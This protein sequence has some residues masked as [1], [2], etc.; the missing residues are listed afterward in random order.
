MLSYNNNGCRTIA[1]EENYP[2]TPKLTLSETLTWIHFP[3]R[4]LPGCPPTL[5]LTLTLTLTQPS[6]GGNFSWGAIVQIFYD[7]SSINNYTHPLHQVSACKYR[8]RHL[9]EIF[10]STCNLCL[11]IWNEDSF[12][13][14]K[15]SYIRA[16][17]VRRSYLK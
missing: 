3:W 13:I 11:N 6:P 8:E 12:V 16:K 1:P 17:S 15:L 4:Q 7:N 10:Q 14:G 5:K 9:N 2:A